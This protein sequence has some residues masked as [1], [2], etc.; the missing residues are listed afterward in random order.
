VPNRWRIY[1]GDGS[2]ASGEGRPGPLSALNV[3]AIN[4]INDE[5]TE[6]WWGGDHIG[7]LEYLRFRGL[8]TLDS[9][10][11]DFSLGELIE[12]GFLLG[13]SLTHEQWRRAFERARDDLDFPDHR[14]LTGYDFYWWGPVEL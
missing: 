2:T 9:R 7:A 11:T 5:I 4:Q 3:Q 13:R 8:A 6:R 12:A 10:I 14:T 1:Y